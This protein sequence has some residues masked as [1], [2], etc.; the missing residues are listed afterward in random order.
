MKNL[1]L[2]RLQQLDQKILDLIQR[3]LYK[4]QLTAVMSFFSHP[5]YWRHFVLVIILISLIIGTPQTRL[6]ISFL[7]LAITLSDQTCNLIK[8]FVKRVRP[9]GPRST[10]GNFWKKLG[11]YSFP[12]SHSANN[13]CVTVLTL[14]W[15]PPLGLFFFFWS[16][17]VG[18]SRV[19]LKNH[20]L[21]DVIVG[22]LIGIGYGLLFIQWVA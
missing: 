15:W 2:K 4:P 10:K 8:A 5:P 1:F 11:H 6:R 12:S 18:F 7:L 17:I 9:D 20:Y 3:K 14:Y 16:F 22:G 13:F 19:Y 21:S